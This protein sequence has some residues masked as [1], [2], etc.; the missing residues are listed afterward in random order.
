MKAGDA[1]DEK[2]LSR[3]LP[4]VFHQVKAPRQAAEKLKQRLFGTTELSD[5]D[6]LFV[7]AAGDFAEQ[8]RKN[9]SQ[10]QED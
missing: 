4:L 5:N 10:N 2:K 1:M 9:K 3:V 8:S 7:A 6:L